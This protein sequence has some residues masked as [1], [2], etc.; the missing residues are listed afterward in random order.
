AAIGLNTYARIDF[1]L[2]E[3]NEIHCLEVNTLPGMTPTSLLPQEAAVE[4][5]NYN[6]LCDKLI[7]LSLEKRG[8]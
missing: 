5:V 7:Q 6:E 3:A 1:L 8:C 2:N 4:G